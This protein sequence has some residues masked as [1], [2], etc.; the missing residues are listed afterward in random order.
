MHNLDHDTQAVL[1]RTRNS[2][3]DEPLTVFERNRIIDVLE[4]TGISRAAERL[5]ADIIRKAIDG[6]K[7]LV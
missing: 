4:G 5:Q 7:E 6:L 3:K 2:I 1:E